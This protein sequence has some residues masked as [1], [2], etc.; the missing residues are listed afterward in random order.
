[1]VA[2]HGELHALASKLPFREYRVSE[3]LNKQ[4][5][6]ADRY[7]VLTVLHCLKVAGDLAAAVAVD[8]DR[9]TPAAIPHQQ[10]GR[11]AAHEAR[12]PTRIAPH[13]VLVQ[14]VADQGLTYLAAGGMYARRPDAP[15]PS[16]SGTPGVQI[17]VGDPAQLADEPHWDV[18]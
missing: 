5:V 7:D 15:A 13:V 12:V 4:P 10:P 2:D 18:E 1:Q 11:L 16:V 8:L 9:S 14:P 6:V 3:F 17:D